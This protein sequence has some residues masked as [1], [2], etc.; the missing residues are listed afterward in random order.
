V[1]FQTY[2]KKENKAL[3]KDF[4]ENDTQSPS[5]SSSSTSAQQSDTAA[6]VHLFEGIKTMGNEGSFFTKN[7]LT[8]SQNDCSFLERFLSVS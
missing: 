8:I 6:F 2:L 5:S 7:F 3:Q 1:S 4:I